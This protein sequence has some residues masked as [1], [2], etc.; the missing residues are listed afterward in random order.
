MNPR[1]FGA[2]LGALAVSVLAA[3]PALAAESR[4]VERGGFTVDFQDPTGV[5]DQALADRM[6]ETF[7]AVYPRLVADFN[8]AAPRRVVF[9]IDPAYEGVAATQGDRIM[10]DPDW[11]ARHPGDIDVVTHELMHVVQA[12]GDN[13]VPGWLTEGVADYVRALYG[14]DNPGAGWA[15]PAFASSQR[16]DNGY[17]VTA[18]FLAWLEGH[19][20]SGLVR[21]LDAR[22]RTGSYTDDA[23]RAVTGKTVEDLWAD[24]AAAPALN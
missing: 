15:L 16:Y 9:V 18:R 6:V 22:M 24:Y 7:F 3:F 1:P 13:A 17:R 11:F 5:A 2:L 19:G 8:P 4:V 10:Y 12:Y 14:V 21:K 23:W 20:H